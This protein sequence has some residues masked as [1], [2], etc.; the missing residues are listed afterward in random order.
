MSR[1]DGEYYRLMKIQSSHDIFHRCTTALI[2]LFIGLLAQPA[3]AVTTAS[4]DEMATA[5]AWWAKYLG[6][7]SPRIPFSFRYGDQPVGSLLAGWTKTTRREQL[8]AG[9]EQYTITWKDPK[10]GLEVRSV[11]VSYSDFPVVEWTVYFRNAGSANTPILADIQALDAV[12]E[13]R[14]GKEEFVLNGNK[15]DFEK[16]DG[17]EP[18]RRELNAKAEQKFS[19]GDSGKSSGGPTGWPYF[20]LQKPGEGVIIAV[21]WPG[22]WAGSF[23]RDA[24]TSVRVR[25][26]QEL[27]HLYLKPGEEIRTPLIAMLFWKGADVVR[28]QNV[29]R[30]WY[31]AHNLPRTQGVPQPPVAQVGTSGSVADIP[32]IEAMLAAGIHLDNCWRDAQ[33]RV[34][35]HWPTSVE[36]PLTW[37]HS[38]TGPY[39]KTVHPKAQPW[40]NT[41]TWDIDRTKYPEGFKPFSDWA[42]SRGLTFMLWFEPE[43]VGN[44]NSWLAKNHP[45]WLLPPNEHIYGVAP[46]SDPILDL[47]NPAALKWLTDHVDAM[48]KSEGIDWYREDMNGRGPLRAWRKSDAKDRQGM[49]ENLYIQGHLQ[50]W[51]ELRRRHPHLRI[52]SCASGGRRND[53]ETMRRAVPLLRSD[54]VAVD[55]VGVVEGNQGHTYGLS[56]WLPFQGT[57]SRFADSYSFR[58]FYLPSF[59]MHFAD[60]EVQKKARAECRRIA[61]YMLL[62]DYYPLTSYSLQLDQWIAWQFDQPEKGEGVVQA[63]RRPESPYESARFKLRGLEAATTYEVENFD[64][65]TENYTGKELMERGLPLKTKAAPV[66]LIF[67]YKRAK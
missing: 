59:G 11:A 26:G 45:E 15:G 7:E 33:T 49:T 23:V 65:G 3:F 10:T 29:W 43:R 22:Q 38:E 66:A 17:Y 18:F 42:H 30:R 20:N 24:A 8:S 54:F 37:W 44:T 56:S 34:G 39:N 27:T 41:G 60:L 4:P 48:I 52:D 67:T 51:D 16:A 40:W 55:H 6:A 53:L 58:S 61:S 28:S 50:F 31:L 35:I 21:G 12:F 13:R 19:P 46:N 63:F 14:A 57:S 25:A 9:R 32:R 36:K 2:F 1:L 47:G 64:G 62:G 5:Q